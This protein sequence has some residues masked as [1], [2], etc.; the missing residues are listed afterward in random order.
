MFV[1]LGTQHAIHMSQNVI[2]GL[3]SSMIFFPHFLINDTIF[4]QNV[5]EHKMCVLFVS[6]KSAWNT[7][8]SDKKW[9]RYDQICIL[10]FT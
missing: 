4:E 7:S 3:S 6:T 8:H 1:A 5:T 2:Y 9:A 10:I